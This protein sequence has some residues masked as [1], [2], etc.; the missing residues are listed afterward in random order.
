MIVYYHL[1]KI[2]KKRDMEAK[3]LLVDQQGSMQTLLNDDLNLLLYLLGLF[4]ISFIRF[5]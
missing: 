1:H 3:P 4:L 2:K 5:L